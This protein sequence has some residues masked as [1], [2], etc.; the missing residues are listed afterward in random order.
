MNPVDF[1]G[2]SIV[3]LDRPIGD[4]DCQVVIG[5]CGQYDGETYSIVSESGESV[6]LDDTTL[7]AVEMPH[8]GFWK[9]KYPGFDWYIVAKQQTGANP[10]SVTSQIII[11]HY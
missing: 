11:F 5:G 10:F 9:K 7:N 4:S 6:E 1:D 2:V 3:L 8:T